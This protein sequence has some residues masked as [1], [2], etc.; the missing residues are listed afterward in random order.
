MLNVAVA[1][2]SSD[3]FVDDV[4]FSHNAFNGAESKMT[5]CFVE[6]VRWWHM[7]RSLISII[8]LLILKHLFY[9]ILLFCFIWNSYH[10]TVNEYKQ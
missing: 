2:S 8:A 4:I 9:I 3:G 10:Q 7:R 6:F 1:R 5:L